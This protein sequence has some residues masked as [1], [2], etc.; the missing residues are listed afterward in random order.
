[1]IHIHEMHHVSNAIPINPLA[2]F[3]VIFPSDTMHPILFSLQYSV[4][5][6]LFDSHCTLGK[7][8]E[9]LEQILYLL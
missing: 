7:E 1:M 4:G 6:K 8:T 9:L 5:R 3:D 2:G